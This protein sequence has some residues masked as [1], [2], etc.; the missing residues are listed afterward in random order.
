MHAVSIARRACMREI[1]H[2][3]GGSEEIHTLAI[4]CFSSRC[5]RAR[6]AGLRVCRFFDRSVLARAPF[7]IYCLRD[8]RQ[9]GSTGYIA[10]F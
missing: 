3:A 10:V 9:P 5:A 1:L 4:L 6:A 7:D 8:R 2:L